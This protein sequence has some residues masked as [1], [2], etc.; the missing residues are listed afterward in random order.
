M[1]GAVIALLLV[2]IALVLLG[3]LAILHRID[4]LLA[5]LTAD[6][7]T[8]K[9]TYHVDRHIFQELVESVARIESRVK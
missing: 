3:I 4:Q 2:V 5:S 7:K 8:V 9:A 6:A 1:I